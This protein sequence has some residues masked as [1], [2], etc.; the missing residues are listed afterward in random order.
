MKTKSM[1]KVA[2]FAAI[3]GSAV[4]AHALVLTISSFGSYLVAGNTATFTESVVYQST[5]PAASPFTTLT[6][7]F[8]IPSQTGTATYMNADDSQELVYNF[9]ITGTAFNGPFEAAAGTWSYASGKGDYANFASGSGTNTINIDTLD[10]T[11]LF[12][13]K[14]ELLPVPEPASIAAIG[15]GVLGLIRLRKK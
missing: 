10:Q 1:V 13:T 8:D 6:A 3:L 14:G 11:S 5:I 4:S 15:I 12:T 7:V 2:A 9:I